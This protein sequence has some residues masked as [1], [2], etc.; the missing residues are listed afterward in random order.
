MKRQIFLITGALVLQ[1]MAIPLSAAQT[2]K[3]VTAPESPNNVVATVGDG[4]V[5]LDWDASVDKDTTSYKIY[6]GTKS[7]TL[8]GGQYE[9]SKEVGNVTTYT[10]S[11][12]KN[13]T[14][15]Y[16][17]ITA[18]DGAG[19]ES[20][21]YSYEA[22]ATPKSGVEDTVAPT[23][24]SAKAVNNTQVRVIFSEPIEL[25]KEDAE[26]AFSIKKTTD[27]SILLLSEAIIDDE[28][29][30]G[31]TILLTT[32][33]QEEGATYE[34]TV[35]IEVEDKA[36]N[37]I[38]SGE[39][40]TASFSGV[41]DTEGQPEA[42]EPADDTTPPEIVAADSLSETKIEI[43]FSEAVLVGGND[44][45]Q[46]TKMDDP[47]QTLEVFTVVLS[48]D[49]KTA[50]LTTET[51][52]P[53]EEY[54]IKIRN[55][56]DVA[57]NLIIDDFT[58]RARFIR[59]VE[60]GGDDLEAPEEVTNLISKLAN[61]KAKLTWTASKN[62]D[63]DLK[64][65]AIYVST[66]QGKTYDE[67]TLFA[68]DT[69]S[70][71]MDLDPKLLYTFKITTRDLAGNESLGVTTAVCGIECP[72]EEEKLPKTGPEE[73]LLIFIA[74]GSGLIFTAILRRRKLQKS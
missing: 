56:T 9:F 61:N 19:N 53:N 18:I 40:D 33:P 1:M 26:K 11:G 38:E 44:D 24:T 27:E 69:T 62:S 37:P 32:A 66:D 49:K 10:I 8:D 55:V 72:K 51:Q 12:L 13:G 17:A 45:F 25:P 31:K 67:G 43:T 50:T 65:Y 71:E 15:Y 35:G 68:P 7:V 23:V 58:S 74:L 73:A 57:G 41:L 14:T 47:S 30:E 42:P 34:L 2:T 6:Y 36:G 52:E 16:F 3:D 39:S 21:S 28:D 48:A 70:F 60:T 64:N 5:T 54:E 22:S 20:E 29:T 59:E 63:G 4:Q 46:I